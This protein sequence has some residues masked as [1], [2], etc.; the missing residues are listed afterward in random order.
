MTYTIKKALRLSGSIA[1]CMILLFTSACEVHKEDNQEDRANAQ[2]IGEDFYERILKGERDQLTAK[3]DG[4]VSPDEAKI[5]FAKIDS[6]VGALKGYEIV[7][8]YSDVTIKNGITSGKYEIRSRCEYER[9]ILD[10][11][12]YITLTDE[13]WVYS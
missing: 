10:E 11:A 5:I 8:T 3:F 13:G 2:A 4:D 6:L 12:I 7:A 1:L 9:G